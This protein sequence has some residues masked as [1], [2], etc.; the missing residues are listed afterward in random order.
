MPG[1]SG[2]EEG[3]SLRQWGSSEDDIGNVGQQGT[4]RLFP[5]F[6]ATGGLFPAR[7][8]YPAI[9]SLGRTQKSRMELICF[10]KKPWYNT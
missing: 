4:A 6:V 3:F 1:W 2:A 5:V 10:Q 9:G 8:R 7:L